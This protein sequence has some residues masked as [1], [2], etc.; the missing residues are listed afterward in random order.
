MRVMFI[1]PDALSYDALTGLISEFV[2]REGTEY[3]AS[4]VS[5]DTKIAQVR[6][7]IDRGEVVIVYD[8]GSESCDLV[9]KT[10]KRFKELVL[11]SER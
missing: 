9:S 3:G 6:K 8:E 4:D 7:Q 5:L 11:S 2:L 1:P 10:S